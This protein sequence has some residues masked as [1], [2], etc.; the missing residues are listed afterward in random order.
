MTEE[1][2]RNTLEGQKATI[3][4]DYTL[5]SFKTFEVDGV[6]VTKLDYTWGNGG[7][8]AQSM[9]LVNLEDKTVFIAYA[10][11]TSIEG[12]FDEFNAMIDTLRIIK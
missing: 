11:L 12:A 7:A 1:T 4:D 2:A 6:T 10:T 5:D 3:G 9:V 8:I